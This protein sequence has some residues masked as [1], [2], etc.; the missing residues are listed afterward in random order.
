[1]KDSKLKFKRKIL[2]LI[3]A[4]LLLLK[5]CQKLVKKLHKMIIEEALGI[6]FMKR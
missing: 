1:M 2:I 3:I 6:N 4:D 5:D